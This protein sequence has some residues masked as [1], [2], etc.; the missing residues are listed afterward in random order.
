MRESGM[1][2][3]RVVE[4]AT[5]VPGAYYADRANFGTIA[6][7]ARADLVLLG[8][9]PTRDVEALGDVRG[10]M[11]RGRWLGAEAIAEGLRA[12]RERVAAGPD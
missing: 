9:N 8:G 11:V 5:A 7:G 12:I 3:R 10:V 4:T 1:N 6:P 2:A